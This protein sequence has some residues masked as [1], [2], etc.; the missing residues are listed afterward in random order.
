MN[1][2]LHFIST[3]DGFQCKIDWNKI[4]PYLA[5]FPENVSIYDS[6][7]N[8]RLIQHFQKCKEMISLTIQ[9]LNEKIN[10]MNEL[11][12]IK[13]N[14]KFEMPPVNLIN[15]RLYIEVQTLSKKLTKIKLQLHNVMVK[16][17]MNQI[18]LMNG[19]LELLDYLVAN[20]KNLMIKIS[21]IVTPPDETLLLTNSREY[22][23][24]KILKSKVKSKIAIIKLMPIPYV[25]PHINRSLM[26]GIIDY[27]VDSK[28]NRT[29]YF[30]EHH[31]EEMLRAFLISSYSPLL[32]ASINDKNKQNEKRLKNP[33]WPY[34]GNT[35][36]ESVKNWILEAKDAI[37]E[38]LRIEYEIN[39]DQENATLILLQRFLFYTT[40]P[41]LYPPS[42]FDQAFTD[43]MNKF[44]NQTPEQIGIQKK[45]VPDECSNK[46]VS[47]L[48][49]FD[50]VASAPVEWFRNASIQVTPIDAAYSI[51]KVHEA[52]SVMAVLRSTSVEK[53]EDFRDK[54]PGF[55]DIFEIWLSLLATSDVF[56]PKQLLTFIDKYSI[57]PG[58]S[59]RIMSHLAY[60]EASLLQLQS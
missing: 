35:E 32:Q 44:A 21:R 25:D 34:D 50:S 13:L 38:W 28:K 11:D 20:P 16:Q 8:Q 42:S 41:L 19:L 17:K 24:L 36:A 46:P 30:S 37:I 59:A 14:K 54:M 15:R 40:Y 51:V 1:D 31:N 6:H 22:K 53:N 23:L 4:S 18:D 27:G 47:E 9:S 56:D 45:F 26:K 5:P 48:F 58:F 3:G 60:F 10:S 57:L 55:D 7:F 12:Q 39:E 33:L 2:A 52:I 49:K 29:F 43:K